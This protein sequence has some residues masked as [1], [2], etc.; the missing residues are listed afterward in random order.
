M[1]PLYAEGGPCYVTNLPILKLS[2]KAACV[3]LVRGAQ[4]FVTLESVANKKN[5][6]TARFYTCFLFQAFRTWHVKF[7]QL[8]QN[9]SIVAAVSIVSLLALVF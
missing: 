3:M 6:G 4:C 8:L 2:V 5:N 9:C 1:C 7:Q